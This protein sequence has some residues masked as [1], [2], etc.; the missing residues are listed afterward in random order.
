MIMMMMFRRFGAGIKLER[1]LISILNRENTYFSVQA[2]AHRCAMRK[3]HSGKCYNFIQR[4]ATA[5]A[6]C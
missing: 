3:I 2:E 5:G 6:S 1:E 4:F